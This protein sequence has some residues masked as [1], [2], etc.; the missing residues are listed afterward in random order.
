MQNLKSVALPVPEIIGG[1]R[2]NWQSLDMPTLPFLQ[3]Y[4]GILFGWTLW[5]YQPNLKP[6]AF[7]VPEIIGVP[8]KFG[9]S[10][11]TPTIPFLLNFTWAFIPMDPLNVLAKFEIRSLSRSWDNR[12]YQKRLGIPWIRP[13]SLSSQIFNGLLFGWTLWMH[14][15]NLKSVAFPVP[16]IIGGTQKL[17]SPWI[18]PRSL[19]SKI[20]NGLLFGWTLLLFWPNLKFVA[21]PIPEIIAIWVLGGVRTPNLGEGEA[22]GGRGWNHS[23]ERWCVPIGPP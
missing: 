16:E 18:R 8:E 22:V 19:F 10:L 20:S 6:V 3:N 5:I 2:K 7:P 11:D 13:R 15:P 17:G 4:Y 12:G 23:K 1:T 21:L 9:Q 14:W